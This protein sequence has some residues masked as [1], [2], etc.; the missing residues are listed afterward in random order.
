MLCGFCAG[1]VGGS[2]GLGGAI[3]LIPV[4]LD[5]GIGQ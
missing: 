1:L 2:L 3:I 4:W 5:M